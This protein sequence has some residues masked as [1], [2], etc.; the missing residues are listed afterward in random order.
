MIKPFPD[1]KANREESGLPRSKSFDDLL[2]LQA[3]HTDE[4]LREKRLDLNLT[5]FLIQG[6]TDQKPTN[7]E[8]K[9]KIGP[10]VVVKSLKSL[11]SIVI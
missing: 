1:T 8:P 7:P 3:R 5:W 11:Q 6:S 9:Y 4:T 10:K 2:F